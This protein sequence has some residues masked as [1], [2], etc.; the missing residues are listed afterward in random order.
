MA[1]EGKYIYCI[2]RANTDFRLGPIGIG[3]RGCVHTVC[4]QE[5][6]AVVSDSPV[7]KYPISRENMMAHQVVM[8]KVMTDYT[9]LPVRFGTVAEGT[10]A[11]TPEDRI[12]E[13]VLKERYVE[14]Q[15]LLDRMRNK[16]ELGLKVLWKNMDVIFQ[17]IVAE[18]RA[19]QKLKNRIL[20]KHPFETYDEKV[21]IG[22]LVQAALEAKKVKESKE[23][24]GVLKRLSVDH[25]INKLFGDR[26]IMNAAFLIERH[27]E[28]EFDEQVNRLTAT[29]DGK[30]DL[31]YVGPVPPCNFVEIEIAW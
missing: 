8:E 18:N 31:K 10:A 22:E 1:E 25:R 5:I 13:R 21:R 24:L 14:F 7:M 16:S 29:L 19:I 3:G 4:Y 17:E 15:D 2:I 30:I 27:R 6:A 28:K 20:S 26:M 23:I 9:V 11:T 12:K